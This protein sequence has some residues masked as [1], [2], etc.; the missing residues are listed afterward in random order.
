MQGNARIGGGDEN[1]VSDNNEP[2]TDFLCFRACHTPW[3]SEILMMRLLSKKQQGA[4]RSSYT[5]TVWVFKKGNREAE[6][7]ETMKCVH[8]VFRVG[9]K[10][11]LS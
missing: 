7:I 9:W 10:S 11:L 2:D 1:T 3:M 8:I 5:L 4:S 6:T